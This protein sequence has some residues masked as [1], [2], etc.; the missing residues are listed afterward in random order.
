[1]WNPV[2]SEFSLSWVS[3]VAVAAVTV[4]LVAACGLSSPAPAATPTPVPTEVPPTPAPLAQAPASSQ[5]NG[6]QAPPGILQLPSIA[7]LITGV[8][9]AVVSIFVES[10]N[11]GL[12]FDFTDQGAGSGVIVRSDGYVVTNFHVIH[13]VVGIKVH[14]PDGK[15]YDAEVV[16]WDIVTDLAVL[17]IEA[18]DSLPVI[19]WGDSDDIRVGDWV[20]AV[21]NAL[22]LKGGPTVTLGIVSA[23]GR[24]VRTER[25]PLYDMIQTDAAINDGNSGGPLVDMDGEVIGISTAVERRAQGI[26][27]AISSETAMPI[28]DSLIEHGR[29]VR[30]LMGMN[31]E[32][33]T[34]AIANR[35]SL[36][37][38]EGVIITRI[39][40]AGP[41]FNAGLEVG[42]VITSLDGIPTSDMGEFLTLLWS[43]EVGDAVQVDYMRDNKQFE[44]SV[45]L[46]ER[47]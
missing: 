30:P 45:E 10:V 42:D 7:D 40:R 38:K 2:K 33:V 9:P 14:L 31:G 44:T 23:R 35:L 21:G 12:F 28:I 11:Q 37:V 39:S 15:T 19:E 4:L 20:V 1:M 32:D 17:K 47:P 43:Y 8:Q 46:V 27:F 13:D 41:A 36:N 18:D 6:Y 3:A 24:T 5:V 22:A 26:G 34:A 29:V 25:E 16:G